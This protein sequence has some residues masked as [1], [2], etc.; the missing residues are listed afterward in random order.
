[1]LRLLLE[2]WEEYGECPRLKGAHLLQI[3]ALYADVETLQ[4]LTNTEHF[5]LKYDKDF[6]R[7]DY[8]TR[9]LGRHDVTEELVEAFDELLGVINAH[10][11]EEDSIDKGL[12]L[13]DCGNSPGYR[14]RRTTSGR[15]RRKSEA[16]RYEDFEDSSSDKD[17]FEDALEEQ[18]IEERFEEVYVDEK[19]EEKVS[20][21]PV[22]QARQRLVFLAID[23]NRCQNRKV[24]ILSIQNRF[25]AS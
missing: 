21:C 8:M 12:A 23:C 17:D 18:D 5:Y 14:E 10:P 22:M 11:Q 15:E 7:G 2:R 4:V 20:C 9:L 3:A 19:D 25:L 24:S 13:M 16:P 6:S 1:V